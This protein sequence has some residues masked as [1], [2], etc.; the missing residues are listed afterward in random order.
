MRTLGLVGVRRDKGT[1]AGDFFLEHPRH[2]LADARR[3]FSPKHCGTTEPAAERSDS[4]ESVSGQMV[5]ENG[6]WRLCSQRLFSV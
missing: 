5:S 3:K 1:C 2:G 4:T 6:V